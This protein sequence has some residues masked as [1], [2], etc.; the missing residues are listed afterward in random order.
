MATPKKSKSI[1]RLRY[2]AGGFVRGISAIG[3]LLGLLGF[4]L[5]WIGL[6]LYLF[7]SKD[8]SEWL[9]MGAAENFFGLDNFLGSLYAFAAG[10]LGI[11]L[12]EWMEGKRSTPRLDFHK[13]EKRSKDPKAIRTLAIFFGLIS[14]LYLAI[15]V[16]LTLWNPW[17]LAHLWRLFSLWP[18]QLI[19]ILLHPQIL[20]KLQL[21]SYF[22]IVIYLGS[23]VTSAILAKK[24]NRYSIICFIVTFLFPYALIYWGSSKDFS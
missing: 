23:L 15:C 7:S 16:F 17:D 4:V 19:F 13:S 14:L 9:I 24:T 18:R 10:T 1:S 8:H 20:P 3:A 5:N 12:G 11:A 6:C 21:L 2:L 22:Y